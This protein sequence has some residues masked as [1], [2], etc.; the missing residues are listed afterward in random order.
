MDSQTN[1]PTR[2]SNAVYEREIQFDSVLNEDDFTAPRFDI[3]TTNIQQDFSTKSPS[4]P[5][6]RSSVIMSS[7]NKKPTCGS[8][9]TLTT[10]VDYLVSLDDSSTVTSTVS[11]ADSPSKGFTPKQKREHDRI[12]NKHNLNL[13]KILTDDYFYPSKSNVP[14]TKRPRNLHE[15]KPICMSSQNDIP[16]SLSRVS[17]DERIKVFDRKRCIVLNDSRAPRL[18]NL[19]YELAKHVEYEPILPDI[20]GTLH[21][22]SGRG[23]NIRL[24]STVA[25]QN[26]TKTSSHV[27]CV[28]RPVK[29]L[30]GKYSD[31]TGES[32]SYK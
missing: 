29:I 16:S 25:R 22:Q 15:T 21:H 31:K 24:R 18:E 11:I 28:G 23:N 14:V 6:A 2:T 13:S 5:I 10:A 17:L 30:K 27:R 32:R 8:D 9:K 26:L 1:Q 12:L 3:D 20:E 19:S 4:T 7:N